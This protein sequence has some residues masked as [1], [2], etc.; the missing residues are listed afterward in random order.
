VEGTRVPRRRVRTQGR[1]PRARAAVAALPEDRHRSAVWRFLPSARSLLVGAGLVA[2]AVGA[3]AAARQTSMFAVSTVEV[4]GAPAALRAQVRHAAGPLLGT[5]LLALDGAALRS[6]LEALPAVASVTY[7]RAFPHTLRL[8][9]VPE[10]P[11]AVLRAGRESWLVSARGRVIARL[12][13]GGED[14][15]TRVWVPK[16]THILPGAILPEREGGTPARALAFAGVLPARIAVASV[17]HGRLVFKLRFGLE[18]RL[19]EPT[20]LR[21]KLAIARRALR[22]LPPAARYLDVSVPGRPVA[23]TNPQLSS[24]G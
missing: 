3:Y 18:L 19:G 2:V 23:G 24:G 13:H 11:V 22:A 17:V 6:R 12:A 7:D 9:V 5:S 15:L 10:R 20:D 8:T 21:L 4:D 14:G 1:P 16:A